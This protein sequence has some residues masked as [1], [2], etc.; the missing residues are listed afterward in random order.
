[1]LGPPTASGS[2]TSLAAGPV[3]QSPAGRHHPS[4]TVRLEVEFATAL[5]RDAGLGLALAVAAIPEARRSILSPDRRRC[6]VYA[7][8]LPPA[9][10]AAALA[11]AGLPVS[12]IS[13]GLAPEAAA[14]LE[15]PSGERLRPI[16]R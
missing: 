4:M 11:E 6:A 8:D 5:D 15:A 2:R 9:R 14:V 3:W 16:G 7:A 1:M 10:L 12:R 13:C